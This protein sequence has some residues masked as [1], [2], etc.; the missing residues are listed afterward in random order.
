MKINENLARKINERSMVQ[1]H[2]RVNLPK[3]NEN[4]WKSRKI[5]ENGK[6]HEKINKNQRKSIK[7]NENQRKSLNNQRK[8]SEK[9][10]TNAWKSMTKSINENPWKSHE[11]RAK[12]YANH[13]NQQKSTWQINENQCQINKSTN[14]RQIGDKSTKIAWKSI[15]NPWK[16]GMKIE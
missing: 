7:I 11:N 9:I 3:I 13:E 8:C 2:E 1:I 6:I 12:I 16:L 14:R 5:N 10:N 15:N 4:V